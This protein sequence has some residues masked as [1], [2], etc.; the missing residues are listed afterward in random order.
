MSS[1]SEKS[2]TYSFS[3]VA[4]SPASE[5][6]P[7]SLVDLA[8]V[9]ATHGCPA[10]S[11]SSQT[12][13]KASAVVSDGSSIVPMPPYPDSRAEYTIMAVKALTRTGDP[14][15]LWPS[16]NAPGCDPL[17]LLHGVERNWRGMV[18]RLALKDLQTGRTGHRLEHTWF[19]DGIDIIINF[20][21]EVGQETLRLMECNSPRWN[22]LD[23][24]KHQAAFID[25]LVS[26]A[27]WICPLH[28]TGSRLREVSQAGSTY[29]R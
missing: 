3:D 19:A 25:S 14:M 24:D 28:M 9:S 12:S 10:G 4:L 2:S 22:P 5:S 1:S 17:G 13:D 26:N 8:E 15:R 7:S 23:M 29:P 21:L 11:V 18:R 6:K 20:D 27:E 16:S